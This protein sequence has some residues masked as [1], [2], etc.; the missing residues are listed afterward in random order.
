M[1]KPTID[2]AIP[3]PPDSLDDCETVGCPNPADFTVEDEF[4]DEQ[5]LCDQC[6]DEFLQQLRAADELYREFGPDGWM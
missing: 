2:Y 5:L 3:L 6:T 4:G 1:S